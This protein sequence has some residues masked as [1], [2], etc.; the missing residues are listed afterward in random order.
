MVLRRRLFG[1]N[2]EVSPNAV[3]LHIN[4]KVMELNRQHNIN[5]LLRA[6]HMQKL[7]GMSLKF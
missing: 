2:V 1:V 6:M 4:H 7:Y 3:K 5:N